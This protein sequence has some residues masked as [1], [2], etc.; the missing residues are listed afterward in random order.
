MFWHVSLFSSWSNYS[1]AHMVSI[2][3]ANTETMKVHTASHWTVSCLMQTPPLALSFHRF[4]PSLENFTSRLNVDT[5]SASLNKTKPNWNLDYHMP[6]YCF[7]QMKARSRKRNV[8]KFTFCLSGINR[9]TNQNM[10]LKT[11]PKQSCSSNTN[12]TNDL[13]VHKGR[14]I[15]IKISFFF[16]ALYPK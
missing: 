16:H 13:N 14:Y 8:L 2:L 3:L 12:K 10:H 4:L 1:W 5:K 6:N 11:L 9:E 7:I 15:M